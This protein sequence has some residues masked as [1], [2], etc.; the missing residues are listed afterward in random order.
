MS[1]ESVIDTIMDDLLMEESRLEQDLSTSED[2]N[3]EMVDAETQ[4]KR[5]WVMLMRHQFSVRAEFP[6]TKTILKAN[7][8][9]N[10][11]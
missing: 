5:N 7:G 1:E 3:N 6:S 11:E 10:Q 2:E 4:A 9:L 8:R